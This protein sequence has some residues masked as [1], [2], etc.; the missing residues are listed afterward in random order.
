MFVFASLF[1]AVPLLFAFVRVAVVLSQPQNGD[2]VQ[3]I[4]HQFVILVFFL[5]LSF[6]TGKFPNFS[7]KLFLVPAYLTFHFIVLIPLLLNPSS[8]K[9]SVS[10]YIVF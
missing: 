10:S 5:P 7:Y 6:P 9:R 4:C 1:L 2:S 3:L 8:E